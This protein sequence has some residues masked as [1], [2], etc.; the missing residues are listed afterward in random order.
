MY[1]RVQVLMCQ[2]RD[3]ETRGYANTSLQVTAGRGMWFQVS[4]PFWKQLQ[5]IEVILQ[6][7]DSLAIF[8]L[9][10]SSI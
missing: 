10:F 5:H 4:L 9:E 1:I 8:Y 6:L 7:E 2:Y 3:P